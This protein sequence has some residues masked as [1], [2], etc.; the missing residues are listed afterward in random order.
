MFDTRDLEETG[1]FEEG[2]LLP[3]AITQKTSHIVFLEFESLAGSTEQ[4][5]TE[6]KRLKYSII[7]M[8]ITVIGKQKACEF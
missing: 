7:S 2:A 3:I 5:N 8:S 6:E 4:L 1:G